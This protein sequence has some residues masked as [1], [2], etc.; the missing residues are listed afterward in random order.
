[1]TVMQARDEASAGERSRWISVSGFMKALLSEVKF[2]E[3]ENSLPTA[4]RAED[5]K[6]FGE[7]FE[8]FVM[9]FNHVIRIM[10]HDTIK[11]KHL[12][13]YIMR[14]V[15]VVCTD[16]Q[17]GVDIILPLCLKTGNLSGNS[18]STDALS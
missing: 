16:N 11:S 12:W 4:Y 3:L 17:Y 6:P 10:D 13:T 14:G 7:T 18:M 8:D 5:D 15:V 2:K 1:M 9:W